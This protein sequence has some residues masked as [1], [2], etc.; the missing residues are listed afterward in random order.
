[1]SFSVSA[2][3]EVAA[4]RSL[5]PRKSEK[6]REALGRAKL[7]TIAPKGRPTAAIFINARGSAGRLDRCRQ[8]LAWQVFLIVDLIYTSSSP[9]G[10]HGLDGYSPRAGLAGQVPAKFRTGTRD[11]IEA[12]W[13]AQDPRWRRL[14][15][16]LVVE[17]A[18]PSHRAKADSS[19]TPAGVRLHADWVRRLGAKK[20]PPKTFPQISDFA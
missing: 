3:P 10:L 13:E 18:C 14:A 4:A 1:M 11:R 17:R 15:K 19:H 16:G 7:E 9:Q 20:E 6:P 12:G 8:L 2:A 5:E